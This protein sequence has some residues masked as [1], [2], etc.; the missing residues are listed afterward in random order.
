[1]RKTVIA[2]LLA[3]PV[4]ASASNLVTNGSF[5]A[6]VQGA[7]SWNIYSSLTGWTGTPNIE[8]RNNVAGKAYDGVNFVELDT[9]ANSK[10]TQQIVGAAGQYLL[11]FWY[12]ARPGTTAGTDELLVS[13]DGVQVADLL[14]NV[15]NATSDNQWINFSKVV[16]FDGNAAL[17]FAAAGLSDSYGG[18]LDKVSLTPVP[19]PGTYALMLGGLAA[20]GFIARRRRID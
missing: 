12:S 11:S 14:K 17:T 8:L 19:E 7:G 10:M 13:F 5:E 20:M 15:G 6:N 3:A 4:L 9:N 2:A 18:S 16:T 1:M